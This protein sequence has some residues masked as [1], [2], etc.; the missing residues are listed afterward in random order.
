MW[1]SQL[2]FQ[3]AK[4]GI[5]FP[6]SSTFLHFSSLLLKTLFPERKLCVM[7]EKFD[8]CYML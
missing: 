7:A 5:N 8:I 1:P 6:L 4:V 2:L 3:M